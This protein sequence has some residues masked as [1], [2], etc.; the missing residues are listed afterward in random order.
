MTRRSF[1]KNVKFADK[2]SKKYLKNIIFYYA[3]SS[4]GIFRSFENLTNY[5]SHAAV[6][7]KGKEKFKVNYPV[8]ISGLSLHDIKIIDS[9]NKIYHIRLLPGRIVYYEMKGNII[10]FYIAEFPYSFGRKTFYEESYE[11]FKK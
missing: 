5:V 3:K 8:T 9:K 11:Y 10:N 1:Y 4:D 6:V 2:Y 7:G